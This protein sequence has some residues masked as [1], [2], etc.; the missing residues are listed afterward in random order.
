[1]HGAGTGADTALRKEG[2]CPAPESSSGTSCP[3][4]SWCAHEE[5][6]TSAR[7]STPSEQWPG[8]LH[9]SCCGVTDTGSNAAVQ[10]SCSARGQ[11]G[12]SSTSRHPL[13]LSTRPA[14]TSSHWNINTCEKEQQTARVSSTPP[15][16]SCLV[17]IPNAVYV[18]PVF[19]SL[20]LLLGTK[21]HLTLRTKNGAV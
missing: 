10:G 11:E 14:T 15:W 17:S 21:D 5:V 12:Y 2:T 9:A 19:V 1:M 3:L 20:F 6:A 13:E 4:N 8:E 18:A 7:T 16:G